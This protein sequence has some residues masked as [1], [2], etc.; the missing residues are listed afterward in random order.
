MCIFMVPIKLTKM[1]LILGQLFF[2]LTVQCAWR[3]HGRL[4]GGGGG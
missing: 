2:R 4:K 3:P 1:F